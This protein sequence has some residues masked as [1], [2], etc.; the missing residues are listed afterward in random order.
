VRALSPLC[1]WVAVPVNVRAC[2]R[3]SAR[4]RGLCVYTIEYNRQQTL[5]GPSAGQTC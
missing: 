4:K 3:M 1:E 2:V 5:N